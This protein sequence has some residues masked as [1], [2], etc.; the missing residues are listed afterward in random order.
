MDSSSESRNQPNFA[1]F[2]IENVI[3]RITRLG[4]CS[5]ERISIIQSGE[6]ANLLAILPFGRKGIRD[7]SKTATSGTND[8]PPNVQRNSG[9]A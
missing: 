3:L 9:K 2:W 7:Y 1:P 5:G 4:D 8:I 6:I